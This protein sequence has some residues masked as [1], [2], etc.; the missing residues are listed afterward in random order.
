MTLTIEEQTLIE[1]KVTNSGKSA[2][3]A[4][5]LYFLTGFLG[6]H[7]FYLGKKI[8]AILMMAVS[9]II[10]PVTLLFAPDLFPYL[11]VL[12]CL[13]FAIDFFLIPSMVRQYSDRLRKRYMLALNT[14]QA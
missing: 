10:F 12:Q 2:I 7:R 11:F 6:L 9:L 1:L 14:P 5:A 8:S 4:Y 3:C 13:W